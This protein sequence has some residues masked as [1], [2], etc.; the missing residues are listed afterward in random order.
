M[1]RTHSKPRAGYLCRTSAGLLA[2]LLLAGCAAGS[3][4]SQS[5]AGSTASGPAS[6]A[7]AGTAGSLIGDI[8]EEYSPLDM[9]WVQ[10]LE[11]RGFPS[12]QLSDWFDCGEEGLVRDDAGTWARSLD[13]T[14]ETLTDS[15]YENLIFDTKTVFPETLPESFQPETVLEDGK[16]PGLGL[17]ALHEE[18]YTGKGVNVGIVDQPL[19]GHLE[20]AGKLRYYA[21]LTDWE[22]ISFEGSSLHGPAVT[23]LLAGDTTG[24]APGV[25]IYYAAFDLSLEDPHEAVAQA[26]NQLL[27]LNEVLP[28]EDKMCVIS[29]SLGGF[30]QND[31]LGYRVL[32]ARA[33]KQGVYL[34]TCDSFETYFDCAGRAL[35]SDPEDFS[36]YTPALMVS[37]P[38]AAAGTTGIYLPMDRRAHAS[39]S[40]P[41]E[42][43]YWTKSGESWAVPYAAG[44]FALARQV[45]PEV[46]VEEFA[47]AAEETAHEVTR[48]YEGDVWQETSEGQTTKARPGEIT[49]KV[50][51]PEGLL[52]AL[53]ASA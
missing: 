20:Y 51:N 11:Q 38:G 47:Q 37:Q 25:N 9:E 30:S 27:D 1:G 5:G 12:S 44:L 7:A 43:M 33:A 22:A 4:P 40:G 13:L 29:V 17:R 34:L 6:S 48:A 45:D 15:D 14:G 50:I 53:E 24:V 31:P 10:K 42:Y 36:V 19:C 28:D 49:I 23:S 35:Q 2:S 8:P 3:A 32:Q 46:T 21:D 26:V 39:P 52:K 16:N 41:E 18:G